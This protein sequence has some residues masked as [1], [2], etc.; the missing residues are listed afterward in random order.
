[1]IPIFKKLVQFRVGALPS[2]PYLN[3]KQKRQINKIKRSK[4]NLKE[5][6]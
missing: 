1:M 4:K 5:N 3:S 6:M 2:E